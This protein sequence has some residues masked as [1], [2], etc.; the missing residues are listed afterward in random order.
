MVVDEIDPA[1]RVEVAQTP[2]AGRLPERYVPSVER[3]RSELGLESWIDLR[4]GIRR[5]A[6]WHQP[7]K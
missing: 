1:A 7:K 5:T 3:A 4:E 2:A 6:K